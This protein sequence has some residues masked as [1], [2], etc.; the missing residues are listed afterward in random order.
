MVEDRE[1]AGLYPAHQD[2]DA[3][4][5]LPLHEGVLQHV[6]QRA[7]GAHTYGNTSAVDYGVSRDAAGGTLSGYVWGD[8]RGLGAFQQRG[9]GRLPGAPADLSHLFAAGERGS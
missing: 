1:S 8:E 5:G 4:P 6:F 3:S 9:A 7:G 2:T